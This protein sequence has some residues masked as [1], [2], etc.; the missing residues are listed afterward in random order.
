MAEEIILEALNK[1]KD[2]LLVKVPPAVRNE[3]GFMTM[4]K[5][6]AIIIA[7]Q[8]P[9]YN[10]PSKLTTREFAKVVLLKDGTWKLEWKRGS[11]GKWTKYDPERAKHARI[12]DCIKEIDQDFHGCFWG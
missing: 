8:R 2:Y 6:N 4:A 3:I 1:V 7:E 10:D 12:E 5:D 11:T 9:R